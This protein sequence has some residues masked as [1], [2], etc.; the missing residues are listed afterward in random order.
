[1]VVNI[2]IWAKTF[3]IFSSEAY[4][5]FKLCKDGIVGQGRCIPKCGQSL[6]EEP[7]VVPL[8]WL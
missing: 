1:M 4:V 2:N 7:A 3:K 6:E 5:N 8:A